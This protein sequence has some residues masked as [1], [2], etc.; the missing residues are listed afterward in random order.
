MRQPLTYLAKRLALLGGAFWLGTGAYAAETMFKAPIEALEYGVICDYL[1]QGEEIP[2]PE[3][4]AGKVRRGG[5]PVLFDIQTDVVPARAGVAF[6]IR[7]QAAE[8]MGT[9]TVM[10]LTRHPSFGE[11]YLDA[12]SWPSTLT[13]GIPSARYFVFE[14]AY[15][16]TPGDWTMDVYL[17][18]ERIVRK[19]FT[20]ID[21]EGVGAAADPCPGRPQVS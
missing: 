21:P 4:N 10:M 13:G 20:V 14:F 17:D 2:A 5:D 7:M 8:S 1:P 15:E 19:G 12:E 11:G 9:R 3:T 18:G 16:M 6:G